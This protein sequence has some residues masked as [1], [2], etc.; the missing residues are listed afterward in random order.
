M[1]TTKKSIFTNPE[2][3]HKAFSWD[4]TEESQFHSS[5]LTNSDCKVLM[6]ACGTGRYSYPLAKL[7]HEIMAFDL[8]KEM[9]SYAKK[10]SMHSKIIYLQNDM[11]KMINIPMNHFD[12]AFLLNN[13]FRYI[14]DREEAKHHLLLTSCTL[15]AGGFYLLEIGLNDN[16]QYLNKSVEWSVC[17][18]SAETKARWTLK[19][20]KY[21]YCIDEVHITHSSEKGTVEINEE[22][23]QLIWTYSE[24]ALAAKEANFEIY[25]IF[26][27]SRKNLRVEADYH[28]RAG[29]YYLLL[30]KKVLL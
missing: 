29:K 3:Y 8:S 12:M 18:D 16:E 26:D 21:P 27:A 6:P 22:Q 4:L 20:V 30:R 10:N 25:K 9:I 2:I 28:Q 13:S 14:L 15:K 5:L 17:Q 23:Y 24:L 1:E 11:R 19:S 7:G